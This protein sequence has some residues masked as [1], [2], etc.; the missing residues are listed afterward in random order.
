MKTEIYLIIVK[1]AI[2]LLALLAVLITKIR[3]KKEDN[4]KISAY[5]C[6]FEGLGRAR[7][8]YELNY[9]LIGILFIIF[10]LEVLIL[11][12]YALETKIGY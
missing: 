8:K 7:S 6:G 1:L 12:P 10:D 9:F 5:E 3:Y 2:S 11:V 4:E